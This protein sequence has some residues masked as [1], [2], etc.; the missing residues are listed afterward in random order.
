MK[1]KIRITKKVKRKS[2]IKLK[3]MVGKKVGNR[4]VK[5][6]RRYENTKNMYS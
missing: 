4:S 1:D 3:R 5:P 6:N 2:K